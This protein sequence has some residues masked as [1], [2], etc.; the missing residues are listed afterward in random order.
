[1]P[2]Q[3]RARFARAEQG[4]ARAVTPDLNARLRRLMLFRV[5]MVTTLLFIAT[6]VEVVSET[7][8]RVNPLYF[9][10]GAT[11]ALTI[12]HAVAL[13]LVASRRTLAVVQLGGDLLIITALV[14]LYG[15]VRT[16]FLVLYPLS[17]LSATM[18]VPR[19]G[20]VTL[21]GVATTLYAAMLLAA[22]EGLIPSQGL[23]DVVMLPARPLLYSIFVLGVACLSVAYLG[24]YLAESLQRAGKELRE[25][26]SEVADLKELNQV[27]VNS[28]QSGLMTTDAGGRILYVNRFGESILGRSS[29][30]LRGSA[31]HAVL[32]SL[33]LG[34][35]ELGPRAASRELTRLEVSYA[36]PDARRLDLG[37]S[38]T[39]L[40]SQEDSPGGFLVVFQDLTEIRRLE[41]EVRTKEKLAA[42]G[43]M[44]AQ[45]AHEIRNPLGSIRG[46]A[47]VLMS[48]PEL[49]E[50]QGRLLSIIS[51]ESKRLSDTLNRFLYQARSP[52]RPRDPV[53]LRPVVEEAVTLL[54]NGA[55]VGPRHEVLFEADDGPHV[56][57]ADPDQIA[58]VF[59]NLARNG[60]EAMPDGGRLEVRLCRV[61][62][63]VVLSVSDEGRGMA[64]DEQ[65]RLFEAR[66]ASTRLGSGLG[67]A[68]VF[69]IVRQHGGDIT[70]RS[71]AD[72]GTR[73]DVRLP[74]VPRPLAA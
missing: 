47:Q 35:A 13:R 48:E 57:L 21:A 71:G 22:R 4:E 73:F 54:R 27:I 19:R 40:A 56:C 72:R 28:I 69:Q 43:E 36:H 46:S 44:A 25:A 17:V 34:P 32:G 5:V 37:V 59:W 55:E 14:H 60:L 45:L 26:A 49:G 67:L 6:Y 30:Q 2:A 15:G 9:V 11:Y 70:V 51:R 68:I 20:A 50:E 33:L 3:F 38:V 39:P 7:L 8:F 63:D 10:I 64:R 41:Q 12:G 58:Q 24:S 42:V 1:V 62:S 23:A 29:S 18:L 53:D 74:L 61:G 65:R 31:V 66:P 16:G 52:A